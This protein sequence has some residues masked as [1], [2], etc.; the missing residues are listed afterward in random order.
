MAQHYQ[1]RQSKNIKVEL[2]VKEHAHCDSNQTGIDNSV[3]RILRIG[4]QENAHR[5]SEQN[6]IDGLA[7]ELDAVLY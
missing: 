7:L 5:H 2:G 1:V 6:V 3:D 4:I